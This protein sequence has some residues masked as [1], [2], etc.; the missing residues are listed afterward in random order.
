[1]NER[2]NEWNER[3]ERIVLKAER[4]EGQNFREQHPFNCFATRTEAHLFSIVLLF[5][6]FK[7]EKQGLKADS[8]L[9]ADA[10]PARRRECDVL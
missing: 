7:S 1:M 3:N 8:R 6:C 2:I 10:L 5:N 4:T 9:P